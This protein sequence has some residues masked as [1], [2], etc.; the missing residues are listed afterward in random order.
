MPAV[1]EDSATKR[2]RKGS[3]KKGKPSLESILGKGGLLDEMLDRYEYRPQQ[4]QMAEAVAQTLDD[5]GILMVE[6]ATG[7]GKTLAYLIPALLSGKTVVVSTGTKALQEQLIDKDIPRLAKHWHTDFSAVLLKGRR[8]YLC[9]MRYGEMLM[10][11]RFRAAKDSTYWGRI[12]EWVEVTDTGDR[13]DIAGLPDDFQTWADLSISSEACKGSK[14]KFYESCFVTQARKT[15]SEARVIVVNHHLF[16][17]DLALRQHGYAE[18]LPEYDA[19]IFDEAHHLE[20]V[21]SQYFG[22]EVSNWRIT[23]LANDIRK[24]MES[25]DVMDAELEKVLKTLGQRGN[26][27]FTLMAFGL[28]EGRYPISHILKGLQKDRIE[29]AHRLMGVALTELEQELKRFK[30]KVEITERLSER[31]ADLKFEIDELLAANDE[32]YTYFMEIR[33]RGVFLHAAPIDLAEIFKT[34]LLDKQSTLVFTSATLS[35]NNNFDYFKQRL[36][37]DVVEQDPERDLPMHEEILPAVF[38]YEDQC[39][40]YVPKRLPPPN[41]PKFLEGVVQIVEYLVNIAEGRAFVLFTSWANMNA[42]HEELEERLE[43]QVL[44]QGQSPKRELLDAFRADEHSVLFATSSFWEGVDVVGDALKLVIID[45]LPFASPSDPLV[46]ARMDLIEARGGNSFMD[47]SV[48]S[49]ALLLKQGFGR[50]IRSREDTGV[51][52]ILDSRIA[53]KRYGKHFIESLPPA[54]VVWRATEVKHWWHEKFGAP[55]E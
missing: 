50:L 33:D 6:A 16:F 36:G 42:V 24:T 53:S 32:R 5:E 51:V 4:L 41:S 8:N 38:D 13:A 21:A 20:E 40:V 14:C 3:K 29:E 25:E 19:V 39:L 37:L 22:I 54:P 18:I 30:D 48:P 55:E 27:F 1:K 17:A 35:T 26:S 15:A 52:A 7:T 43:Y 44:K 12:K 28:Y 10:N 49:A 47:F 31:A 2:T 11:P 46:R 9:K 23:E 45:K 34:R